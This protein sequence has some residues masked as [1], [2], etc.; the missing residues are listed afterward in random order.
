V[1]FD[2]PGDEFP[3]DTQILCGIDMADFGGGSPS[4]LDTCS[5]PSSIPNS[6]PS[7]C[8]A[9]AECTT[10]ADCDDGNDCTT[11]SCSNDFCVH[12]A[13]TGDP[14]TDGLFCNGDEICNNLG[15]CEPDTPRD[16][17]DE[18][19]CTLDSCDE[20]DDACINDPRNSLC[21]NDL[22]CDGAEVCNPLVGCEDGPAPDCGDGVSCTTDSCDEGTDSCV[23][24]PSDAAC[25]DAL[26]CNGDETCDET[27]G[28]QPG[29]APTCDDSI[30]C[31]VDSCDE[32]TDGCDFDPIDASC[33]NGLFC[34]G[35][36]TCD[37]VNGC[38]SGTPPN[39]NDGVACTGDSCD[40]VNDVCANEPDNDACTDGL[41]CSGVEICDALTGCQPGVDPCQGP[42][43]C[44]EPL[45]Q[46]VSCT[47]D[48]HCDN[49]VYCD[50]VETCNVGTG[51]C[52]PGAAVDCDDSVACTMDSCDEGA[53]ACANVTSDPACDDGLY[54]N[55]A[56][57][58]DAID[59][60]EAGTAPN[61]SDGVGCTTDSCD[62]GTDSCAN[63]PSDA[64]CDDGLYCNGTE[65][66]D[67][68]ADCQPGTA[69]ECADGFACSVDSCDEGTDACD[70]DFSTCTCGDSEITGSEVCDPP[71]TAGTFEDCNNLVDDDGD[72]K[73]DCKDSGCA[74][75]AR[76][77]ICDEGCT[78]DL[79]CTDVKDD[80][81]VI[82]YYWNGKHDSLSIHGRFQLLDDMSP[83]IDG[84]IIE[85]S[86]DLGAIYR[87]YLP[88]YLI[89]ANSSGTRYAF[90]DKAA[91]T[92]G[93][94]STA[95][96]LYR[97]TL[98]RRN[99]SD[100]AYVTFKIK[101]YNDF[102]FATRVNM[103]TQVSV[104][105]A[106]GGLTVDWTPIRHGWKLPLSSF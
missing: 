38:E 22:Y 15:F 18:I 93:A 73:I 24:A 69:I 14:C 70:A 53:D 62:E 89:T 96:G 91:R 87:A 26:Y 35:D 3:D 12:V 82:K 30:A 13:N 95:N 86:N 6:D 56:E 64:A 66:C 42:S 19:D 102:T 11:D 10:D 50:G 23:N 2:G 58:C 8:V 9:F 16:C 45:D 106:T 94:E 43:V 39:C 29:T 52:Q 78:L 60:C 59:G 98:I 84:V 83:L 77:P 37:V 88:P 25:D 47:L 97:V 85:I 74:P 48:A 17:D 27:L 32:G 61:C 55:G 80:P 72:G 90:L 1:D 41:F 28:C 34:D 68:D 4:L 20:L 92:D 36:E 104:G 65:T 7:D 67:A 51:V 79:V 57:T 63:A 49:S 31:T 33:S 99:F 54:C 46:C 103:T 40:E 81:A 44:S 76:D 71:V 105:T 100:G 21:T 75:G 101:A 5:Y